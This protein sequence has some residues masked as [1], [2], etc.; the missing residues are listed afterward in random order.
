M[1]IRH[2][3]L[4]Y[5]LL[6]ILST[7]I[8]ACNNDV[9]IDDRKPSAEELTLDGD[10]ATA[11]LSFQTDH[12]NGLKIKTPYDFAHHV[13]YSADGKVIR[14]SS[15][16]TAPFIDS[17]DSYDI[18]R[19]IEIT[20]E[21]DMRLKVELKGN[22]IILT[23][24]DNPYGINMTGYIEL[25]YGYKIDEISF[26]IN[27]GQ[28]TLYR[29]TDITYDADSPIDFETR[30][31]TSPVLTYTNGTPNPTYMKVTPGKNRPMQVMFE[32]KRH[33]IKFTDDMPEVEIPTYPLIDETDGLYAPGCHGVKVVFSDTAIKMDPLDPKFN[34][35]YSSEVAPYSTKQAILS[36]DYGMARAYG[37]IHAVNTLSGK[38]IDIKFT[39]SVLQPFWFDLKWKDLPYGA[40]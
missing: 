12:L 20:T 22:E 38:E 26:S 13:Y 15:G 28:P 35:T 29:I 36:T 30:S 19:Y 27:P 5:L 21:E 24:I 7:F 2:A 14:E 40:E 16:Y 25:E 34:M 33:S 6:C 17:D 3:H 11:S 10:G 4:N 1:N 9:F 31:I 18:P 37:I 8:A 39:V 23:V 32:I